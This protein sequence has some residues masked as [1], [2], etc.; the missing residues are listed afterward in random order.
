V[1]QYVLLF[2]RD[3]LDLLAPLEVALTFGLVFFAVSWVRPRRL[4][5][6]PKAGGRTAILTGTGIIGSVLVVATATVASALAA[7]REDVVYSGIDGWLGRP[8]PLLAAVLVVAA[9][10]LL[11][12]GRAMPAPGDRAIAP[13]RP[14]HAYAP[15]TALSIAAVA[16][17]LVALTA[18]WHTVI[19]TVA[20]DD[21]PFFGRVA[22]ET[23]L[24]IYMRF[25]QG[26]GYIAG[27]GWPNYL[28][29]FVALALAAAVLFAALRS[30]ANRP[31]F[32][33]S[34][35][36]GVRE[37]RELTA[38]LLT[39]ILLGGLVTTLGAVWMHAGSIGQVSVGFDEE[40]VGS[41]TS[42][43]QLFMGSSYDMFA[44]PLNLAG[45]ALQGIGVALLLRI[46]TD[47]ARSAR[48]NNR[49]TP[50]SWTPPTETAAATG[51]SR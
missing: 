50:N 10:A 3:V 27:V 25:N 26:Y 33:R 6:L 17:L 18:L 24:P 13:R 19:A 30:D 47:T 35:M 5:N 49:P 28:A 4:I 20:P 15:R 40:W 46:A 14:W 12:R 11:M 8:S 44:R 36:V 21:G 16:A 2:I 9:A 23:D 39:L 38:R 43:P 51:G 34:S 37:E 32:A 22:T 41:D 7:R 42:F 29:T 48:G 45:Y 31:I 1:L